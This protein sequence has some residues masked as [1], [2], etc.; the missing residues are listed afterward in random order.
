M[1]TVPGDLPAGAA[2][3]TAARP[4]LEAGGRA[5]GARSGA[6]WLREPLLHFVLLG[7]CLFALDHVVNV[8]ED[9][10]RLIVVGKRVDA[11]AARL[12]A[13]ARGRAP[14]PAELGALRKTWLDNEILYR[15]GVA[16][17]VDRGDTAIRERVIFKALSIVEANLQQPQVDEAR[18][19]A[20][21]E[22]NRVRYDEP[23]RFD[24]Q[25]AV[26]AGDTGETSVR[27]FVDRLNGGATGGDAEAGLRVF[28]GRPRD[29]IVAS[30]GA[31]TAT[32][33]EAALP[34]QWQAYSTRDGWRAIRLDATTPARPADFANLA[35]VVRQDWIDETA[36]RQRTAAVR[37][38]GAKYR[39][40]YEDSPQ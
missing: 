30:Y 33:L 29:N 3:R 37:A 35:G 22:Q 12:F 10:P 14:T 23:A 4:G 6:R 27:A 15:E 7:A 32:A 36:A 2:V 38:L 24:F 5:L 34:G 26:L 39:I 13:A 19:R 20:W 21:F 1:S 17:Q 8:R 11:E 40:R 28:K 31:E 9:D 18:L 25:E 16:L